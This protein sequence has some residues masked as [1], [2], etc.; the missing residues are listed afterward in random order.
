MKKYPFVLPLLTVLS[1][2]ADFLQYFLLVQVKQPETAWFVHRFF[3]HDNQKKVSFS[4]VRSVL[5][6]FWHSSQKLVSCI[7]ESSCWMNNHRRTVYLIL[8]AVER[9]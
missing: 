5:G 1:T 2:L 8:W 3:L 9:P 6:R 4:H 7:L